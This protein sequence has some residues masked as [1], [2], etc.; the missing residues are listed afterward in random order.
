MIYRAHDL[1]HDRDVVLKVLP[2]KLLT[3][4]SHARFMRE[5]RLAGLVEHPNVV[6]THDA[7]LMED[8][9]PYIVMEHLEGHTLY[10]RISESGALD[11]EE[12]KAV[13]LRVCWGVQAAHEKSVI[14]RDL[15]PSNVL[16]QANGSVKVIDFGLSKEIHDPSPAITGP[17]EALGTPSYMS[18]EQ[19]F[20]DPA[21]VRT[22]VW[23]AGVLFYEMLTG[24]E[25]FPLEK[26]P[27]GPKRDAQVQ[28]T[29]K[30]I[31]EK[32]PTA[33][34]TRVPSLPTAVDRLIARAIEKAPDDRFQ[35]MR[36]FGEAL[37][38]I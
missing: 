26:V 29:F 12:A 21:D 10:Q 28:R 14:H 36:A 3:P 9:T 4:R 22:D 31:L 7:G 20:A 19:V 11:L 32:E 2:R 13:L 1:F 18:P 30:A 17:A 16:V 6:A 15:K 37:D 24:D 33:A 38:A 27:P 5:A 23:G 35:S 25:A 34:S 8:G